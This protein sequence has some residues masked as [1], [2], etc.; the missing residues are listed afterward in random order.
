MV[1]QII[2]LV[3]ALGIPPKECMVTNSLRFEMITVT[4][5]LTR[6]D[7]MDAAETLLAE[8]AEHESGY[9]KILCEE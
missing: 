1:S 9:I 8:K 2:I 6:A 4:K 3:C 5:A 7:C